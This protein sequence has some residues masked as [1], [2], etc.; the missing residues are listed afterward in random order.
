[1]VAPA[2]AVAAVAALAAAEVVGRVAVGEVT[3]P[4]AAEVAAAA[5]VVVAEVAVAVVQVAVVA[6]LA[7]AVA[8]AV[9]RVAVVAVVAVVAGLAAAVVA[10]AAGAAVLRATTM[11]DPKPMGR[12]R[13]PPVV[14]ARAA[15][16]ADPAVAMACAE[17]RPAEVARPDVAPQ[18][19]DR[20][21]SRA[22]PFGPRARSSCR[23]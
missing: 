1:V 14:G 4:V 7:A 11:P 5:R 9:A 21:L 17:A 15:A 16:R 18:S 22:P 6:G 2:V 20:S 8:A 19:R 3:V 12:L 13:R 23:A 10:A